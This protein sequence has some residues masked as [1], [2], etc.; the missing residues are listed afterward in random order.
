MAKKKELPTKSS[1]WFWCNSGAC[2][3][4]FHDLG[5]HQIGAAMN[6]TAAN[7]ASSGPRLGRSLPAASQMITGTT[8]TIWWTHVIG[9]MSKPVVAHTRSPSM[10]DDRR[11]AQVARAKPPTPI[12]TS[13]G[14]STNADT[15]P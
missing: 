5:T 2:V 14:T 3:V 15:G 1:Q 9:E 8:H 7:P 10:T 11:C 13:A 12:T 6:K 4:T